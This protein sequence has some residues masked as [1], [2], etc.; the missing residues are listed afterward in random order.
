MRFYFLNEI[1]ESERSE[2]YVGFTMKF[3]PRV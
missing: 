1:M 3:F 2:E